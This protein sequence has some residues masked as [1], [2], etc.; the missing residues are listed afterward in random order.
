MALSFLYPNSGGVANLLNVGKLR[1]KWM[2]GFTQKMDP[3]VA[4]TSMFSRA[5]V[6]IY[7]KC[8]REYQ[9]MKEQL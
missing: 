3:V 9:E 1:V 2:G 5:K 6:S 8:A 7:L 4:R